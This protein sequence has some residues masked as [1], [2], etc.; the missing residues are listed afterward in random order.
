MGFNRV[1]RRS[2]LPVPDP[3]LGQREA[4]PE[5]NVIASWAITPSEVACIS[6]G[7]RHGARRSNHLGSRPTFHLTVSPRPRMPCYFFD[8]SFDAPVMFG[9]DAGR[10]Q[11]GTELPDVD[12]ARRTALEFMPRYAADIFRSDLDHQTLRLQVRDEDGQIVYRAMMLLSG[13][14]PD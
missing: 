11:I 10:D 13:E 2:S 12:A 3:Y 8:L 6:A 4:D 9:P 14:R 7:L 5:A 1:S